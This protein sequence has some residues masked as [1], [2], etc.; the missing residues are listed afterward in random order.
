MK[1]Q[2]FSIA[3]AAVLAGFASTAQ[4][5][6]FVDFTNGYTGNN[7]PLSGQN[8]WTTNDPLSGATGQEVG[9]TNFVTSIP[10]VSYSGFNSGVLGGI[11]ASSG[12]Y[13]GRPDPELV[14][15]FTPVSTSPTNPYVRLSSDFVV[16]TS[17]DGS[18]PNL[19]TF[20]FDLR[21]S[22]GNSL[23]KFTFNPP[24]ATPP[25]VP[26]SDLRVNWILNGVAQTT[27]NSA[28]PYYTDISY[29]QY[30]RLQV[31]LS[32][33]SFSAKVLTLDSTG[34]VLSSLPVVVG[35]AISGGLNGLDIAK[36]A[37]LWNLTN[38]T[39]GTDPAFPTGYA[40]AGSNFI[41]LNTLS[42]SAVPEPSTIGLA[43]LGGLGL[44]VA[45]RRKTA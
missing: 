22:S 30:Y 28:L 5:D 12:Y 44:L 9:E 41:A 7:D 8:G 19:D 24:P 15:D 45:R 10:N 20:G 13:P 35:G 18:Y 16:T 21:D 33:T 43:V 6:F 27:S 40:E 36:V 11:Y 14:Y 42:A 17:L 37:V 2:V 32:D 34:S 31:D 26:G 4:A 1:T 39:I 29:G 38:A 25:I 23:V 3:T